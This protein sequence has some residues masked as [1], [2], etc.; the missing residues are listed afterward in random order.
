MFISQVCRGQLCTAFAAATSAQLSARFR[1]GPRTRNLNRPN[2]LSWSS[3]LYNGAGRRRRPTDVAGRTNDA[4]QGEVPDLEQLPA[5]ARR[6]ARA[7]ER[8]RVLSVPS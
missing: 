1:P 2:C 8:A 5:M 7:R 4:L 6:H 3:E